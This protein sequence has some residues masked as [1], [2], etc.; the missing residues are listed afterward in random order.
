MSFF[1][2]FILFFCFVFCFGGR[3]LFQRLPWGKVTWNAL[4]VVEGWGLEAEGSP[5]VG[6]DY[7]AGEGS[8]LDF[9]VSEEAGRRVHNVLSAYRTWTPAQPLN[10]IPP[11][12]TLPSLPEGA[13]LLGGVVSLA[14]VLGLF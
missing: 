12:G 4:L 10:V 9:K 3:S 2:Y 8:N 14:S 13:R 6:R 7:K 5:W 11:T 1:V